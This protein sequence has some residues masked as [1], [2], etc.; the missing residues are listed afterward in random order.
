MSTQSESR[1]EQKSEQSTK[2]PLD[3]RMYLYKK[4][5]TFATAL[6]YLSRPKLS[7]K[8]TGGRSWVMII[9]TPKNQPEPDLDRLCEEVSEQ[10]FWRMAQDLVRQE[11]EDAHTKRKKAQ[12]EGAWNTQKSRAPSRGAKQRF[13]S[14]TTFQDWFTHVKQAVDHHERPWTYSGKGRRAKYDRSVLIALVLLTK[15]KGGSYEAIVTRAKEAGLNCLVGAAE[16]FKGPVAVPCPSY[17]HKIA[18]QKIPLTYYDQIICYF[19]QK[20]CQIYEERLQ[21]DAPRVFAVDGTDLAGS[22]K[23]L[24]QTNQYETYTFERVP[25]QLTSRLV[26]NT[27][28]NLTPLKTS[29]KAPLHAGLS[30]LVKGDV[31]LGDR[32]YDIE[33]NHQA[34]ERAGIDFHAPGKRIHGNPYQGDARARTRQRFD[35]ILYRQRKTVERP[36][37]NLV[38]RGLN[39]VYSR[40]PHTRYVELALWLI[41]HNLLAL[42]GQEYYQQS[43]CLIPHLRSLIRPYLPEFHSLRPFHRSFPPSI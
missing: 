17:L 2:G 38:S 9:R 42:R 33:E 39:H 8:A 5:I 28:F 41:A 32:L 40:S 37:G 25:F 30:H 15:L 31:A 11:K 43:Y 12:K 36:F 4:P 35:P 26:T 10:L 14:G 3:S 34:A 21:L 13:V 7:E 29:S 19:D 24:Q 23:V 22:E 16:P 1:R 18:T 20:V 27:V 6:N